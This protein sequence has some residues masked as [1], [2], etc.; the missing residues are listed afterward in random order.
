ML[1][2]DA[3]GNVVWK[4]NHHPYGER[5]LKQAANN[6]STNKIGFAGKP[7]DNQTGLSYMGARYYDPVIGRFMGVDPVGFQENNIHSFNRYAYAN[8][9]PYKFVD[10]DGRFPVPAIVWAAFE[11]VAWLGARSAATVA[12]AEAGAMMATGAVVPSV[13]GGAVVAKS[14]AKG[15]EAAATGALWTSTK[16]ETVAQNAFRHFKDHGADFGAANTVDY[17][18]KSEKFLHNP[19]VGVLSKTRA[20]GDIVRYDSTTNVF[21]VMDKTGAPRTFFKPDPTQHRYPTNLDYFHAQ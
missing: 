8:N 10:P 1:A 4:E 16:Y 5:V 12:I 14:T 17:V 13:M 15:V 3:A 2:T 9:N 7:F 18:R 19:E 6:N 21:G 11:T 20:N